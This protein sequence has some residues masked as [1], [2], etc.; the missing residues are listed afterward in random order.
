MRHIGRDGRN[1]GQRGFTLIELLAVMAIIGILAAIVVPTVSSTREAGKEAQAKQDATTVENA[2]NEK[3][4]K[5]QNSAETLKTETA[6][7]TAKINSVAATSTT[8]T[9]SG[10][11]P[12]KF[13]TA[14]ASAKAI[15]GTEFPTSTSPTVAN[16]V[17]TDLDGNAITSSALLG[18]YTAI[19]FK[20]LEA[21]GFMTDKPRSVDQVVTVAGKNFHTFLWLFR[22]ETS[23]SGGSSNDARKV[24]LLKLKSAR[25]I[26]GAG[27][28][29][30]TYVQVL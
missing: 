30:L 10:R 8:Q 16:V 6:T 29:E 23:A 19:D 22:K 9:T 25:E 28:V 13:I 11:W 18:G 21:E 17:I 24:V 15:Y 27:T 14:N 7:T 12:E 20:V 4:A 5:T 2:A 1:H 3:F 26:E